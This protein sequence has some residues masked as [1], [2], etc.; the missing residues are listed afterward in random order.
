MPN[1][2]EGSPLPEHLINQL[3]RLRRQHYSIRRIA[4]LAGVSKTTVEKYTSGIAA[5]LQAQQAAQRPEPGWNDEH[6]HD[7]SKGVRE[8]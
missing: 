1:G 4:K 2:N 5:V 3:R 8:K 7:F 6:P